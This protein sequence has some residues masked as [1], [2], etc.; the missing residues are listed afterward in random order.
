MLVGQDFLM[1]QGVPQV[2]C[3][4]Y[5]RESYMHHEDFLHQLWISCLCHRGT[6]PIPTTCMVP[7]SLDGLAD[8]DKRVEIP[9]QDL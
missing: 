5:L 1:Q 9:F 7:P 8:V 4:P 2:S 6:K 3:L